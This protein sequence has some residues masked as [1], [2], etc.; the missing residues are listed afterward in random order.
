MLREQLQDAHQHIAHACKP[1][2][3]MQPVV[4]PQAPHARRPRLQERAKERGGGSRRK[5][6]RIGQ[7]EALGGEQEERR[8]QAT[9]TQEKRRLSRNRRQEHGVVIRSHRTQRPEAH[10]QGRSQHTHG[11]AH[12][13][14]R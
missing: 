13:P 11:Q 10:G 3:V 9:R 6:E 5:D 14:A 4:L 12:L 1:M 7:A 8:R 2:R